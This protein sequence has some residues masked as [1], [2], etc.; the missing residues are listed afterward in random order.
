[1]IEDGGLR[2][3][4]QGHLDENGFL[5]V[6]GRFKE[7]YKLTNGKYVFPATIEEE[8]KLLP[9]RIQRILRTGE[10]KPYNVH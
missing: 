4:D 9:V 8:L 7:E 3:G 10:G 2:T 5:S 1:M 6:T